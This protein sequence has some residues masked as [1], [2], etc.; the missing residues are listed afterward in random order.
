[1]SIG[2]P[3]QKLSYPIGLDKVGIFTHDFTLSSLSGWT[4]ERKIKDGLPP[5]PMV[6][7]NG[8]IVCASKIHKNTKSIHVSLSHGGRAYMHFNPNLIDTSDL[9][10]FID[11]ESK[12]INLHLSSSDAQ[13]YRIDLERTLPVEHDTRAYNPVFKLI[14]GKYYNSQPFNN[15]YR[16]RNKTSEIQFYGKDEKLLRCEYKAY[17]AKTVKSHLKVITFSDVVN[18]MDHLADRY[19]HLLENRIFSIAPKSHD[20]LF[21]G[22]KTEYLRL[23]H[24]KYPFKGFDWGM[25]YLMLE[26]QPLFFG[27]FSEFRNSL[28]NDIGMHKR[29][30]Q[31]KVKQIKEMALMRTS[32]IE[33]PKTRILELYDELHSKYLAA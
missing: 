13:A 30:A 20:I 8:E 22:D 25:Q 10:R 27:E 14:D 29:K 4:I 24:K 16:F 15:G 9:I 31:R 18:N 28:I 6:R 19:N 7:V 23:M 11:N 5:Q 2:I 26:E 33:T 12:S 32:I 1:M 17:N 3:R 21:N